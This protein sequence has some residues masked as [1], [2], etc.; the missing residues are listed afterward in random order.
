MLLN[1]V[2]NVYIKNNAPA[3]STNEVI[4]EEEETNTQLVRPFGYVDAQ[5]RFMASSQAEVDKIYHKF[6]PLMVNRRKN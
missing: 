1:L 2:N 5:G 4:E 6:Y 3:K